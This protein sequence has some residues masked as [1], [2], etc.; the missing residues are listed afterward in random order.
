MDVVGPEEDVQDMLRNKEGG[1]VEV[2]R[3]VTEVPYRACVAWRKVENKSGWRSCMICLT[4][5]R[6][7]SAEPNSARRRSTRCRHES[8]SCKR[9][10]TY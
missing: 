9:A 10:Q 1:I 6:K 7:Q 3:W 5:R 8:M 2:H 4:G